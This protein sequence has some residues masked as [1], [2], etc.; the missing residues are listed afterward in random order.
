MLEDKSTAVIIAAK[1]AAKT[2]S[3]AVGS[4]LRQ[5]R[6]AEVVFVDDG[7]QD[8]TSAA[9]EGASDGSGRLKIIRLDKNVGPA[10]ARNI[11]IAASKSPFICILDADDY[12]ASD[13]LDRLFALAPDDWDFLADDLLFTPTYDGDVVVD[14]LLSKDIALPAWFDLETLLETNIHKKGRYRRETGF[15]K[16]VMRRT[17][18]D[19][20]G[21]RYDERLRLGE[22][23]ILYARSLLVGARFRVVESCGYYAVERPGSL[24]A[25]HRTQDVAD[26]YRALREFEADAIRAGKSVPALPD[27]VRLTKRN[28]DFREMLDAKQRHGMIGALIALADTPSSLPYIARA[29]LEAKVGKGIGH[30]GTVAAALGIRRTVPVRPVEKSD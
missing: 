7:S 30:L 9:A 13:R 29:V 22:D 8:S 18:L 4:A 20:H 5:A 11:A 23:L 28:L 24:S 2:A 21:L 25:S 3:Y 19:A 16:P 6:V 17:F 26:L 10:R 15:L 12:M 27:I 1:N 14:R